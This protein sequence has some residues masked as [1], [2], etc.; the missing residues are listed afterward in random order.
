MERVFEITLTDGNDGCTMYY[1]PKKHSFKTLASV[2]RFYRNRI[3]FK[4]YTKWR[5]V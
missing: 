3:N 5:L 1:D 2:F 4:I